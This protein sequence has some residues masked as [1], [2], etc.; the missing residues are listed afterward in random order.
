M[1]VSVILLAGGRGTRMGSSCPK[2]YLQLVDK[3]VIQ[4]SIDLF[5][6]IDV[7]KEIV[8]VSEPE[9]RHLF[10]GFKFALPGERRQDSVYNGL[11]VVS[12]ESDLICI[13]DSAR[14]LITVEMVQRLLHE[15]KS[16]GAAALGVP[17]K[18]T[19]KEMTPE[20]HV[21][22]T[23]DRSTLWEI[24]TPQAMYPHLLQRGFALARE[25]GLTVTDDVSL[26]EFLGEPVK[27]VQGC[28]R[29]IK[30]TTPEDLIVAETYAKLQ[31]HHCL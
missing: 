22:Q 7:V 15:A 26:V 9:Y 6:Q 1:K 23:L 25:K 19:I 5:K 18:A 21:K 3:P 12:R 24:Q 13:H 27:L 14:P 28:Y 11:Q 20:T 10:P 8:V 17:V 4:Y 31:N 30:I 2:Q 29:N 16:I